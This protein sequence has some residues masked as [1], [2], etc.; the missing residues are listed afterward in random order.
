MRF[1]RCLLAAPENPQAAPAHAVP[2]A[3][4]AFHPA[5]AE[6]KRELGRIRQRLDRMQPVTP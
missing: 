2:G 6:S 3:A 4:I 5:N 1:R